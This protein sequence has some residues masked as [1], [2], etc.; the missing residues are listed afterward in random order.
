MTNEIQ[1]PDFSEE[2]QRLAGIFMPQI[3]KQVY[4][5]FNIAPGKIPTLVR[6]V[7]YTSADAALKIIQD[8][9]VWMRNTVCMSDYTEVKHGFT[10]LNNYFSNDIK[11]NAF[12]AALERCAPGATNE[13]INL[14]NQWWGNI[15]LQTYITSI[16]EH[17]IDEDL[18]GRLSMWRAFGANQTR[19]A[20]VFNIPWHSDGAL[21]LN[22]NFSPV[23]YLTEEEAHTVID[24]VTRNIDVNCEF[25][26][27]IDHQKI[28]NQIFQ[29]LL[30]SVTCLKHPC[31]K[32]ERE[33]RAIYSPHIFPSSS[34]EFSTEVI[35]EIP[36]IVYKIP[37][38]KKIPKLADLDFALLFDRLIIGPT[39]YPAPMMAAFINTLINAGVQQPLVLSSGIPLRT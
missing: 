16:S 2:R 5:A 8:K 6:F 31:F 20:I 25:L 33:W 34:M 38:D 9:R 32:E 15:Q 3:M 23:A 14:F 35:G 37:L 29:M 27:T 39:Q 17:L 24:D 10:I 13:A 12:K 21:E 7:H 19:V 36:Q 22:L 28:V 11:T 30:T 18:H 4:K 1:N 26:K